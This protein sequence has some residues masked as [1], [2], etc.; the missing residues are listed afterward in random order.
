[1]DLTFVPDGYRYA[2]G[3]AV[4]ELVA[5]P[6]VR[7]LAVVGSLARGD[8]IAGSDADI[9]V[10]VADGGLTDRDEHSVRSGC[11]VEEHRYS[12]DRARERLVTRPGHA[13]MYLDCVVL[14]D[15]ERLLAELIELARRRIGTYQMS[16]EEIRVTRFWLLKVRA[17]LRTAISAG[18]TLLA[19]YLASTTAVEIVSDLFALAGLPPPPAGGSTFARI[20]GLELAD[21]VRVLFDGGSAL[22]AAAAIRLIDRILP[23]LP[24]TDCGRR[25]LDV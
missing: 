7:A 8:A 13:Y 2:V 4:A 23:G 3:A 1:M 5:D 19:G 15:P 10:I 11:V 24:G 9:L 25:W 21:D 16:A 6:K 22:R 17:K 18:D 20:A 14:H 12:L